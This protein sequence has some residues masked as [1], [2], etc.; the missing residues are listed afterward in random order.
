MV[1]P[2]RVLPGMVQ[3]VGMACGNGMGAAGRQFRQGRHKKSPPLPL[4][5]QSC[6]WSHASASCLTEPCKN[7]P[8]SRKHSVSRSLKHLFHPGSKFLKT[9]KR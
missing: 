7:Q 9:L 2:S 3:W 4:G 6:S 1:W 8:Q 5:F